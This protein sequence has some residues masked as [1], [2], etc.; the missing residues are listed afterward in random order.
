MKKTILKIDAE[1]EGMNLFIKIKAD[2]KIEEFF[3]KLTNDKSGKSSKWFSQDGEGLDF[4]IYSDDKQNSI[5]EALRTKGY[6]VYDD[7]GSELFG[8]PGLNLALL[9]IIGISEGITFN[10]SNLGTYEDIKLYITQIAEVTK[11]I[12]QNYIVK[13]K[14]SAKITFDL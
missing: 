4:Y 13:R 11:I 10:V 1:K 9:R 12:Y 2:K 14:I 3:K 8:R 6:S 5:Y 7:F